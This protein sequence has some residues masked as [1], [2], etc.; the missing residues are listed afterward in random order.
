[1]QA[2]HKQA[3]AETLSV[4]ADKRELFDYE[5]EQSPTIGAICCRL[6]KNT[7]TYVVFYAIVLEEK[8]FMFIVL[9]IHMSLSTYCS[10]RTEIK[11]ERASKK[12]FSDPLS[13]PNI[14]SL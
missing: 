6:S 4:A 14:F 5:R 7:P 9:S 3:I 8:D 12:V 13:L 10:L 1:M 11:E 2:L